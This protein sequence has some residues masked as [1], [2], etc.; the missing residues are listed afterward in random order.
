MQKW[1][2]MSDRF[3]EVFK[4]KTREEWTAVFEGKD[5]CV[6]PVLELD[7]VSRHPHNRER[8][9]IID[10][11]SVAQPAPA[12]RLSRTPG[13]AEKPAGPRGANTRDILKDLGYSDKEA[14]NLLDKEIAE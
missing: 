6:A 8:G 4:T 1:P 10:I 3:T 7:E 11:E 2:E 13:K 5:A 9:L 12:P 14:S